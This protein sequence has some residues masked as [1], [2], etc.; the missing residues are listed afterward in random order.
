MFIV[1]CPTCHKQSSTQHYK[2][3]YDDLDAKIK[4]SSCSKLS[5]VKNWK[6][7]CF[8]L[9]HTCTVHYCARKVKPEK[10]KPQSDSR[11]MG[12][13]KAISNILLSNAPYEQ[14]LDDGFRVQEK[15]D[16]KSWER[17]DKQDNLMILLRNPMSG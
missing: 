9:W 10:D 6:C 7:N 2:F 4:C 16:K 14:L 8:V 13:G 15:R 12:G 3:Q 11:H 5:A 1:W 17:D